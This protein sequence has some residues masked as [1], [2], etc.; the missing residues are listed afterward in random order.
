MTLCI[1]A[2][3]YDTNLCPASPTHPPIFSFCHFA[4]T[5]A[6]SDRWGIWLAHNNNLEPVAPVEVV[7]V[8]TISLERALLMCII[9]LSSIVLILNFV[10]T[11]LVAVGMVAKW[12]WR[13]CSMPPSKNK[14]RKKRKEQAYC[15]H[16]VRMS[17]WYQRQRLSAW[18]RR[19]HETTCYPLLLLFPSPS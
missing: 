14:S 4:L 6:V 1:L 15:E 13:V 10:R 3:V 2:N 19:V 12:C 9:W 18:E 7:V 16:R 5:N 8:V 17:D 11:I